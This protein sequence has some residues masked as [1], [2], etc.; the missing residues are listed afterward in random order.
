M[1]AAQAGEKARAQSADK[2]FMENTLLRVSGALFCHDAKRAAKNADIIELN[3]GVEEKRITIRPDSKLGQPGPLAHKVFVALIKKHSD[4]GRPVQQD[5]SFTRR[6]IGRLIGRKEWGGKDSEQLSRALYEIHHT[7]IAAFFRNK[8]G[9]YIEHSFNI[10]PEI[11]IE[12]RE[13]LSDP[14]EACTITLARPIIA[15]LEDEHFTCLNHSLMTRLG[16]IGQALYMRAFFHFANLYDGR[17]RTKLE[18][19]KRYDDMCLEW[20][21]GLTVLRHRSKIIGEQLGPHLDQLVAEGILASYTVAKAKSSDN[22][23]ITFRPGETFFRDYDRFYRNRQQGGLQFEFHGEQREISEPLRVAQ[24]FVAKR[25]GQPASRIASF[26]SKDVAT[27]REI[28]TVVSFAEI[29]DFIDYALAEAKRT[30]FDVQTLGGIRQY[31]AGY[32][33]AKA[34]KKASRAHEARMMQKHQAETE[35]VAY[36]DYRKSEAR[37]IFESLTPD[38]RD[39]IE[40]AA[41]AQAASFTGSLRKIMTDRKRDEITIE[42]HGNAIEGFEEWRAG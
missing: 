34:A 23:V 17:N 24:L 1:D 13:F 6:E 21:G 18:F 19:Q 29:G 15:S 20:L 36:E 27:A 25:T 38:E 5:I 33:A 31:L 16:T 14:I 35:K 7:F 22:F 4:Y 40:K 3:R 42:R 10:F 41:T 32:Q 37:R 11:L 8:A 2:L 12:R 28:L 26:P 39:T 30:G 9:R